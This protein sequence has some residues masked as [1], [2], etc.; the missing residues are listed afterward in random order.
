MLP[1][2][3]LQD[4]VPTRV[5]TSEFEVADEGEGERRQLGKR[6]SRGTSSVYD[7]DASIASSLGRAGKTLHLYYVSGSPSSV[8][9]AR[10]RKKD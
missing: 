6:H 5:G 3:R 9:G 4:R 2:T 10:T 8:L 1:R 7:S